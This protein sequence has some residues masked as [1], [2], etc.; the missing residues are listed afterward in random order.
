MSVDPVSNTLYLVTLSNLAIYS[1]KLDSNEWILKNNVKLF[2]DKL[3]KK[4]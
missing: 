1:R 2:D 3:K 4:G